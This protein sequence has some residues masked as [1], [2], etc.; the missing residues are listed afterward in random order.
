MTK[1][2]AKDT[3]SPRIKIKRIGWNFVPEHLLPLTN[4]FLVFAF[5]I[6]VKKPR[7]AESAQGNTFLPSS[8]V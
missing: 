5:T 3:L 4:F 2:S 8:E 7:I 6:I 1:T